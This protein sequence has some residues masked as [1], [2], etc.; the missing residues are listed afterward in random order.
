[1]PTTHPS[2]RPLGSADHGALTPL[3]P[4]VD[5]AT[6]LESQARL[7]NQWLDIN[8][9]FWTLFGPWMQ[10][11]PWFPNTAAALAEAKDEGL[12]PAQTADGLPD[13]FEAQARSWNHFL[14]A[15][16]SFWTSLTWPVPAPAWLDEASDTQHDASASADTGGS[17]RS[18]AKATRTRAKTASRSAR[19]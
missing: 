15:H 6:A 14:D 17:D 5:I 19:R 9:N 13:A 12:E 8:R 11:V 10:P 3:T 18:P 2:A 1:M 4:F 7:W 16:R